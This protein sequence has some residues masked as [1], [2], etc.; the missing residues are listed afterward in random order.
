MSWVLKQ[1][2]DTPIPFAT[3]QYIESA[4]KARI[5]ALPK[6]GTSVPTELAGYDQYQARLSA[7]SAAADEANKI[8]AALLVSAERLRT[9][10]VVP[11]RPTFDIRESTNYTSSVEVNAK[12]TIS[13]STT[14]LG[15]VVI[16][17]QSNPWLVS[18]GIM[19][20]SLRN[21][22]FSNAPVFVDGKPVFEGD[23]TVTEVQESTKRPTIVI[24]SVMLHY[25][26]FEHVMAS[27]GV[28]LNL[29]NTTAEFMVGPS[30]KFYGII[31]S[32]VAHFGRETTLSQG[33]KVGDRL[34]LDPPD[35][36]TT[37]KWTTR[38]ALGF[39]YALPM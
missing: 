8:Q 30:F 20:S 32:P 1:A 36:P 34:G 25:K 5:D 18:T 14:P 35:P 26:F 15:T 19:F 3:L 7:L 22:S 28:G 11:Q 4:L 29:G 16:R 27:G 39:S 37:S 9:M 33:V 13:G 17:W 23:K 38:F 31:I 6:P 2:I 24:P 10:P 12:E 21:R